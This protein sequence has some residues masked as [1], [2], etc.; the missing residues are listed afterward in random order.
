MV[1]VSELREEHP[2]RLILR[3]SGPATVGMMMMSI[4]NIVDR[5][6]IGHSVGSLGI[7]ALAVAHPLMMIKGAMGMLV[8][9]G[10]ATLISLRM[11]EGKFAEAEKIL[12][13]ALTLTFGLALLASLVS[14]IFLEPLLRLF[15]ASDA[16]MPYAVKYMR[17]VLVGNVFHLIG[18]NS[19]IRAE[20]NPRVAMFTNFI[21]AGLNI[22]L[23]ALFIFAF[24]MGVTGAAVATAISQ[25]LSTCYVLSYFL[26][27]RS[28]L[29]LSA[30]NLLLS[31]K[32][33]PAILVI[34]T[35]QALR[36]VVNS[37]VVVMLNN[38]LQKYG[39][40][41]AVSA[42][43]IIFSIDSLLLMPLMGLSN[44]AQPIIGFNYGARQYRRV[45]RTFFY[46]VAVA[47]A[48]MT[49]IYLAMMLAPGF[50]VR[51][52]TSEKELI[53]VGSWGLRIFLFMIPVLGFQT[54]GANY[55]QAIGRPRQSIFLNLARQ[56]IFLL[57]AI[58]VLPRFFKLAGVW[59]AQPVADFLSFMVTAVFIVAEMRHLERAGD[60]AV[61]SCGEA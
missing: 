42:M 10:A 11:G 32:L 58:M 33:V 2:L 30:A 20:G 17:P 46:A 26:R 34:G 21:G 24:G 19:M 59:A 36:H 54:I 8:G 57:P 40:D 39:G 31:R 50:F 23:D 48:V 1:S 49:V 13:N 25:A 27:G 7:A 28:V 60:R 4:Y 61:T 37:L 35:P 12:G 14:F 44:G 5:I 41:L 6:F 45:R 22:V 29:K 47:T 43:G 9:W 52:F 53:A 16:I 15:G 38:S 55:Y 3:F 51:L 18:A 56:A